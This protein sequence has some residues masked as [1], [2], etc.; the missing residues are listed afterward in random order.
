MA[1]CLLCVQGDRDGHHHDRVAECW[2]DVAAESSGG[3][4]L[5]DAD[6]TLQGKLE[7]TDC[8]G[9]RVHCRVRQHQA[10]YCADRQQ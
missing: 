7:L 2:Q 3:E 9:R 8:L 5:P 4:S 1:D 10:P 6:V